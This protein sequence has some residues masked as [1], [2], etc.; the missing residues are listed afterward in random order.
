MA[1]AHALAPEDPIACSGARDDEPEVVGT[2][3]TNSSFSDCGACS[4]RSGALVNNT[5]TNDNNN[6]FFDF[7]QLEEAEQALLARR[8]DRGP[9]DDESRDAGALCTVNGN[10]DNDRSHFGSRLH[11][12]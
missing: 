9:Y 4:T 12:S 2:P 7:D 11:G 3:G 1:C 5:L 10:G 8:A 6:Y